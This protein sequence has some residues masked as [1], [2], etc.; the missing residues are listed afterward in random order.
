MSQE[1]VDV[2]VRGK[3]QGV[4]FRAAAVRHAHLYGVHGWVSNAAD[5]SVEL[6]LQGDADQLDRMLSWLHRGPD[7]AVVEQVELHRSYSE[8][9]YGRFDIR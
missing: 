9:Q 8:K 6:V 7:L 4:G 2:R 5:G 3:V 1:T